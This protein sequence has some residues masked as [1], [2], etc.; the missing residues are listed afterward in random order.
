M[1]LIISFLAWGS[2]FYGIF[3]FCLAGLSTCTALVSKSDFF[4]AFY[5]KLW[6]QRWIL[7]EVVCELADV[8][9]QPKLYVYLGEE[10]ERRR[11]FWCL[12]NAYQRAYG[13]YFHEPVQRSRLWASWLSYEG[14]SFQGFR[15]SIWMAVER[16]LPS[17]CFF[18]PTQ[19]V[20][21][22]ELRY[23]YILNP[24]HCL[25]IWHYCTRVMFRLSAHIITSNLLRLL[26]YY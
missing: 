26:C 2:T 4:S 24:C 18:Y 19:K 1:F 5:L 14:M 15:R 7:E 6:L 25:W 3:S 12:E 17:Y 23:S 10:L 8:A 9:R 13:G 21:F 22:H 11:R 20:L 16:E